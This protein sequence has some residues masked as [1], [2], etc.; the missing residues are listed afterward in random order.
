[1]SVITVCKIED[2]PT[3]PKLWRVY[4]TCN[5]PEIRIGKLYYVEELKELQDKGYTVYV[6]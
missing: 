2:F 3:R 1:M 5:A 6:I 4:K